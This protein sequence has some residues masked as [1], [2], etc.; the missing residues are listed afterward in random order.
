MKGSI[1]R[2]TPWS[3]FHAPLPRTP[4]QSQQLLNSLTSSF[5]RELDRQ[6]PTSAD[7]NRQSSAEEHRNSSAHA[8]DKH[9]RTILE[10]PLFRVA[11][12]KPVPSS[13]SFLNIENSRWASEPMVVFDELVASGSA[14][15]G[16]V[17][18]CL[19]WQMLLARTH[20]GESFAKALKDSQA[21][22]RVVSWWYASDLVYRAELFRKIKPRTGSGQ[23]LVDLTKFMVAEGLHDTIFDWLRMLKSRTLAQDK[24]K[25]APT[26][27]AEAI[28]NLLVNFLKAEIAYGGGHA[29]A[30]HYY[31]K[32][33][34]MIALTNESDSKLDLAPI[35][36][37]AG[38]YIC[39]T[40]LFDSPEDISLQLYERY[41]TM[42]LALAPSTTRLGATVLLCHPSHPD[43][44]PFVQYLRNAHGSKSPD[45]E[46]RERYMRTYSRA[47]DVLNEKEHHEDRLFLEGLMH[48]EMEE[49]QELKPTTKHRHN[50]SSE[51]KDLLASLDLAFT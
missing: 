25:L 38:A 10:N 50:P 48:Q 14:T 28:G 13:Q 46:S 21:G 12:S 1:S 7:S 45:T 49:I 37:N 30:L 51:E 2:L 22:S 24:R 4:R 15:P 31:L 39:K 40:I 32:A 27:A 3:K 47:L 44:K 8:T 42:I 34:E 6:H 29:S 19:S 41:M 9:L 11:P 33:S 36:R 43:A 5:R 16:A 26:F 35:V 20:K 17:A 23:I 18:H